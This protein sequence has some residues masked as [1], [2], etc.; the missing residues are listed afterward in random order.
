LKLSCLR[1]IANLADNQDDDCA[2]DLIEQTQSDRDSFGEELGLHDLIKEV[3]AHWY[4]LVGAVHNCL[5]I[6]VADL[7]KLLVAEALETAT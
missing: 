7:I 3:T 6:E 2:Q 1:G 5:C 4:V